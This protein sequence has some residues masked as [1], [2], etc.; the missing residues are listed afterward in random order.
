MAYHCASELIGLY[1][2]NAIAI[3][4]EA[5]DI[6]MY[7]IDQSG[8]ARKERILHCDVHVAAENKH[9]LPLGL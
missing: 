3:E 7:S 8:F 2:K 5:R 4:S 1:R 6:L 9:I